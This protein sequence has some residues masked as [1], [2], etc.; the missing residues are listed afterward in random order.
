MIPISNTSRDTTIAELAFELV[1]RI[2]NEVL[3]T[4][5]LMRLGIGDCAMSVGLAILEVAHIL[6]IAKVD[7]A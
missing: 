4:Y 5:Y 1:A 7:R 3:G 2:G 6:A